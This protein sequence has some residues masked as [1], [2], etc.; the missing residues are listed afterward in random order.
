[1]GRPS[2]WRAGSISSGATRTS[3][4]PRTGCRA[5]ST[6]SVRR[7]RRGAHATSGSGHK[8]SSLGSPG[9]FEDEEG[10][11]PVDA[12][13]EPGEAAVRA[14]D[15]VTGYDDRDGVTADRGPDRARRLR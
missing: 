15:P 4:S 8:P 3:S 7:L 9:P 11:L 14:D 10:P 5:T 2:S 12:A 6:P 1:M 13:G